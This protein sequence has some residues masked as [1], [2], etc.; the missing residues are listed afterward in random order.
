MKAA[1]QESNLASPSFQ[2]QL[3]MGNSTL[4]LPEKLTSFE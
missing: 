2:G 4:A 3:G 1:V